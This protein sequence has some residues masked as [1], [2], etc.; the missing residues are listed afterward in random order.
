L[1]VEQRLVSLSG[2]MHA[3]PS[4]YS[5]VRL[6]QQEQDLDQRGPLRPS[7]LRDH[8]CPGMVVVI[9][10]AAAAAAVVVVVAVAGTG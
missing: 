2:D 6:V 9:V 1:V 7:D 4:F 10:V 5:A 3:C 8:P